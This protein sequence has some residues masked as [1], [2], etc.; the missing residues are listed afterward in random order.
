MIKWLSTYNHFSTKWVRS[1]SKQDLAFII[2][3]LLLLLL[4]L[5]G[6]PCDLCIEKLNHLVSTKRN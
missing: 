2:I 5:L 6:F 4:L 3:K 1:K